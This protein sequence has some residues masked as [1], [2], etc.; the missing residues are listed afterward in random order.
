MIGCIVQARM[1]SSRLPGK[2]LLKIDDKK[3]VLEFGINQLTSSNLLD[4][5]IVATTNLKSDDVIENFVKNMNVDVFRGKSN[6]VLD[7]Y[8]QCAKHFS[9]D[10]IVRITGDNPLVDPTIIDNLIQKFTLNSYDY[11][12]NAHVRTFPYG[13]EVEI[14]SFES[15]EQAWKNAILPSEREHVTPYFYNNSNLFNIHNEK[16]SNDISNLRWTVDR[17]DDLFLVK[18]IV[19]KIIKRPILLDDILNLFSK[20]PKLFKINE[21]QIRDEG[22]KKSLEEDKDFQNK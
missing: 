16:Q 17:E 20:E 13:T 15:L 18:S 14:F 4:K 2:T 8:F 7:R 3:T 5:I 6:D 12:S 10:T 9:I 19:S 11:L 1:G 22:Y 21:T